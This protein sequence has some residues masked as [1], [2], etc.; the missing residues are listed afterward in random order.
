[1]NDFKDSDFDI[2]QHNIIKETS[3]GKKPL[4]GRPK[5]K[6]TEKKN[7]R[8]EKENEMQIILNEEAKEEMIKEVRPTIEKHDEVVDQIIDD[9]DV[10]NVIDSRLINSNDDKAVNITL[11]YYQH[12]FRHTFQK[13][14][15]FVKIPKS[16]KMVMSR[17]RTDTRIKVYGELGMLSEVELVRSQPNK[18]IYP[19]ANNCRAVPEKKCAKRY[20]SSRLR[21]ICDVLRPKVY[22]VPVKRPVL[23][24]FDTLQDLVEKSKGLLTPSVSNS[25]SPVI[26]NYKK[27]NIFNNKR[28]SA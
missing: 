14:I 22:M 7:K 4:M 10:N 25:N 1:M 18:R 8:I 3:V 13:T 23:W 16:Q 2:S 19:V 24:N 28:L 9:M 12:L 27:F 21:D 5:L 6:T 15:P 11:A 20:M 26:M 17:M